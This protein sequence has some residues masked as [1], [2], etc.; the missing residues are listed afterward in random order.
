MSGIF[1][2]E[3]CPNCE[4]EYAI[5]YDPE[6]DSFIKVSKCKCD[7]ITDAVNEVIT[8][9][10]KFKQQFKANPE[11]FNKKDFVNFINKIEKK[12][13]ELGE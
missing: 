12:L 10:Q 7:R 9:L 1:Y 5:S 2:T 4:E 6:T 3:I 13:A 8:A 11:K